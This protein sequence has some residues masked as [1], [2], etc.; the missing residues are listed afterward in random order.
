[1]TDAVGSSRATRAASGS[2]LPGLQLTNLV[3]RYG[4]TSALDHARLGVLPGSITSLWG[5]AGAGKTTL[6]RVAAGILRPDEGSVRVQG[7]DPL[8][9]PARARA[10]TGWLPA[11]RTDLGPVTPRELL[12]AFASG[13]EMPERSGRQ[14]TAF[15]LERTRLVRVADKR[16]ESLTLAE[17]T[18]LL[19]ACAIIHSPA[20]ILLDEPFRALDSDDRAEIGDLL[21][22]EANAGAAVL[23]TAEDPFLL[24]PVCDRSVSIED[25]RITASHDFGR[26]DAG[27]LWRIVSLDGD[28]LR[29]TLD[30][31]GVDYEE[32]AD[33]DGRISQRAAVD[34]AV[35]HEEE[36]TALLGALAR[37]GVPVYGFGPGGPVGT[38][39]A[40]GPSEATGSA[41]PIAG[42]KT[43]PADE[44]RS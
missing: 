43:L 13:H 18:K 6:L 40:P 30:G 42:R 33:P 41:A 4:R 38:T 26:T 16:A 25:G 32:V 9:E 37:A 23:A 5:P 15:L 1:M 17:Q 31:H 12:H 22:G 28:R 20:V 10:L 36:A 8:R 7:I 14:R 2:D 3:M 21:R 29:A 39:G 34:V 27:R 11:Q 24:E 19:L 35:A 44:G